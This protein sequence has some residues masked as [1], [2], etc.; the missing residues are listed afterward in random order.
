[1]S[2]VDSGVQSRGS[3]NVERYKHTQIGYVIIAGLG[4]GILIV[5][6]NLFTQSLDWVVI[7]IFF[8]MLIGAV[9]FAALTIEVADGVLKVSFGPG[10]NRKMVRIADIEACR[11]VKNPWY[12]GWG[13]RLTP[14]GWLY[15]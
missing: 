14:H 12:Y 1:M 6:S 7:V 5:L 10:I 13:L 11:V 8:I 3:N 15:A 4:A 2:N 9:L